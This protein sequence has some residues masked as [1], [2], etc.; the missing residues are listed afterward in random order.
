MNDPD[1]DDI[2]NKLLQA[3]SYKLFDI[4]IN[5]IV[6]FHFMKTRLNGCAI[7]QEISS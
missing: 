7:N 2:I 4:G 6:K 5:K 3:R 1:V